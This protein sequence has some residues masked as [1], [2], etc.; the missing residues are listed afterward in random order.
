MQIPLRQR[1][2]YRI[3]RNAVLIALLLGMI[4][5]GVQI[6][7]DYHKEQDQILRSIERTLEVV[8][9]SAAEAV[10]ATNRQ[11]AENIAEGLLEVREIRKVSLVDDFGLRLAET[12]RAPIGSQGDWLMDHML[13]EYQTY[14]LPLFSPGSGNPLVAGSITVHLDTHAVFSDFRDRAVLHILS[15]V[16]RN[17]LLAVI[18]LALFNRAITGPLQRMAFH[19]SAIDLDRPGA[20]DYDVEMRHRDD[21][22]GLLGHTINHMLSRIR[23]IVGEL[24]RD[25]D[26]LRDTV[27]Q[28]RAKTERLAPDEGPARRHDSD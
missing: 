19:Y 21:E 11:Q 20:W 26:Q 7:L 3:S 27:E 8:R 18:L 28:V 22:L 6:W 2:S 5:G 25:R 17:V 4:T 10:A 16:L 15:G 1:L 14:K 24:H 12:E 9:P 13:G 23:M